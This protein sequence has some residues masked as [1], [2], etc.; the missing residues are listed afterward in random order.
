MRNNFEKL[1]FTLYSNLLN[2]HFTLHIVHFS[3]II[4]LDTIT[5]VIFTRPGQ[6]FYSHSS[7]YGKID[8]TSVIYA[9]IHNSIHYRTKDKIHYLVFNCNYSSSCC[10]VRKSKFN[11]V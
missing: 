3:F 6:N 2:V 7:F 10:V 9:R 11:E 4:P 1:Q 5:L 8:A